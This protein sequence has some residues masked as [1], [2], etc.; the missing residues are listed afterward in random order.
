M[1]EE[2][3][4][5]KRRRGY[6]TRFFTL[7]MATAS[8]AGSGRIQESRT[9]PCSPNKLAQFQ[10]PKTSSP[11]SQ[12][13]CIPG[14]PSRK[15]D[16]KQ[17]SWDKN[18]HFNMGCCLWWQLHKP[19]WNNDTKNTV[20]LFSLESIFLTAFSS[21]VISL[22]IISCFLLPFP[23]FLPH[24]FLKSVCPF[25]SYAYKRL[26]KSVSSH[27]VKFFLAFVVNNF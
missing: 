11:A 15:L 22:V 17:S 1:E 10:A 7:Q 3:R 6:F 14:F 16:Q 23:F 12:D 26:I 24:L 13:P 21:T 19:L 4:G 8:R 25:H 20:E 9:P 27:S 5:E 18:H 2:R